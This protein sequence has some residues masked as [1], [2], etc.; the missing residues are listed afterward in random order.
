MI[1]KNKNYTNN[2]LFDKTL[3]DGL[4]NGQGVGA[5]KRYRY[6]LFSFSW[7]GCEIIACY[8]L[9]KLNGTPL[10][11]SE[12]CREIYP[13]GHILFGFFGTNVYTLTHFFKKHCIPVKTLYSKQQFINSMPE[14]KHGVV[15]FWTGKVMASS[16]HT[17]AFSVN[18]SGKVE[19]Y[20]RY[21]NTDKVYEYGSVSEAFGKYN[22]IV[23]NI[24]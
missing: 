15:S 4:L 16:I 14:C 6:G 12:I 3:P 1:L 11:L 23:A 20:N 10:P 19:V 13:Y 2:K 18:K 5:L 22:F 8:N 21:N 7:C 24:I 9:L 17:V